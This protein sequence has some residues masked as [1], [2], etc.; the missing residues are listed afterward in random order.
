MDGVV[1]K[2]LTVDFHESG[3]V[4]GLNAESQQG[5][6]FQLTQ[7]QQAEIAPPWGPQQPQALNRYAYVQNNP[8]RYTDPDGHRPRIPGCACGGGIGGGRGGPAHAPDG[9]GGGLPAGG[10]LIKLV[11]EFIRRFRWGCPPDA[12]TWAKA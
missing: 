6:W 3:L 8:L 12:G 9:G 10:G 1:L 5:F 11:T 7:A 4:T 2:P